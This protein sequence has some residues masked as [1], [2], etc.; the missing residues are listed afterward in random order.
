MTSLVIYQLAHVFNG[1]SGP[2]EP[3]KQQLTG[4]K[5]GQESRWQAKELINYTAIWQSVRGPLQTCPY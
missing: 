4:V 1:F 5:D 2:Q 3:F